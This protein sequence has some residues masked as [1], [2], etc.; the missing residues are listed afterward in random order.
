MWQAYAM[1]GTWNVKSMKYDDGN[2]MIRWITILFFAFVILYLTLF[3]I[4]FYK[5]AKSQGG[6]YEANAIHYY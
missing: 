5:E 4:K 6:N 3:S 2:R 1:P